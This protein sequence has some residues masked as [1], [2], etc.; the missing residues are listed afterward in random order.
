MCFDGA[1]PVFRL[2]DTPRE[3]IALV[4]YKVLYCQFVESPHWEDLGLVGPIGRLWVETELKRGRAIM[5][6]RNPFSRVES[7]FK[8]KFRKEPMRLGQ[9]DFVWQYCQ[10][11]VL[12]RLEVDPQAKDEVKAQALLDMS[13]ADFVQMLPEVSKMDGHS[14]PQFRFKQLSWRGRGLGHW[15][16]VRHIKIEDAAALRE[17]PG[18]DLGRQTNSTKHIRTDLIWDEASQ[19]M[20]RDIYHR[21][22]P[23][24]DYPL[25]PP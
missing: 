20:I 7:C 9:P 15:P 18:L 2:K 16:G 4:S 19:R 12:D 13:L 8:D 22:F 5:V 6:V 17:I 24:G 14:M 1:V 25:T 23:L 3:T 11:I 10:N 21:D